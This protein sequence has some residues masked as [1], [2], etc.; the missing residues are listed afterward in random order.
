MFWLDWVVHSSPIYI[1]VCYWLL[2]SITTSSSLFFFYSVRAR[3]VRANYNPAIYFSVYWICFFIKFNFTVSRIPK[4]LEIYEFNVF[5]FKYWKV[6]GWNFNF[7]KIKTNV[8]FVANLL[9][10]IYTDK[11]YR[12]YLK[13]HNQKLMHIY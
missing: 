6:C 4:F 7:V 11:I 12:I 1:Y 5:G 13:Q 3:T 8:K 10:N 9:S 2:T